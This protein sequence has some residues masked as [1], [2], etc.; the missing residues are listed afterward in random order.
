VKKKENVHLARKTLYL[1]TAGVSA[2][3][4]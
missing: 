2:T 1:K 4:N 3:P